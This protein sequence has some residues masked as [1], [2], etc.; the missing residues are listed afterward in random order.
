MSSTTSSPE[1]I[2]KVSSDNI[3]IAFDLLSNLTYMACLAVAQLPRDAMLKKAGEQPLKTAVF[4]QQAYFLAHRLGL[5]YTRALQSVAE[6]AKADNIKTLLLRFASTISSGESEQVFIREE[7]RLEGRRYVN[8]YQSSVENLKKWTDAYAALLVSVTLIVVV[9]LVSTLTGGLQQNF[10]V[11]MG[12]AM[13]FITAVG[14]Y[15]ILRSAPY[16]QKTYTGANGGPLDRRIAKLLL[17]IMGTGGLLIALILGIVFGVGAA[18]L[19]FGLFILPAGYFASKDD[20]KVSKIDSEIALFVRNLGITAAAKKG[21]LSAAIRDMDLKS[22]GSLEPYIARL[23]YRLAAR[24]P[25]DLCWEEFKAETGSELVRRST[26]MLVEGA[27]MGGDPEEVSEIAAM[28][29]TSVSE[30]RDLRRLTASSFTFLALPMHASMSGLLMFILTIITSFNNKLEEVSTGLLEQTVASGSSVAMG[31]GL[32]IFNT[33]DLGLTTAVVTSVILVL[34]VA[35]ALAPK[36]AAGGNNL[37]LVQSFS[38]TCLISGINF[39]LIPPM[40]TSLFG[41]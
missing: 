40:A 28:Y 15:V 24:I 7:T 27:E 1:L 19:S 29:A 4:F 12:F 20:R 10:V 30:M 8:E 5:E 37:K 35:N 11:L 13:F 39:L 31:S 18:L 9:A 25:T 41:V 26:G 23:R 14:V 32:D 33:Q 16:E 17:M 34:T 3:V 2:E 6:R 22:M 36:F 38:L 21:T